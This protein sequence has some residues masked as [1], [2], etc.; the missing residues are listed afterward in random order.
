MLL[1]KKPTVG[2]VVT[3]RLLSGEEVIGKLASND[4]QGVKLAKPIQIVVQ[5]TRD[6]QMGIQFAPLM[7]STDEDASMTFPNSAI[8]IAPI[9]TRTDVASQYLKATTSLEIPPS[10]LII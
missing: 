10:G 7:A 8:V 3:I 9:V 2:E 6:N 1:E 4:S 5:M